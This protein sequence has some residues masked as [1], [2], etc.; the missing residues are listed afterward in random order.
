MPPDAGPNSGMVDRDQH[1]YVWPSITVHNLRGDRMHSPFHD[2]RM[3]F[4][5]FSRAPYD[6]TME[7]LS[8]RY[9]HMFD[10]PHN[11]VPYQPVHCE[12]HHYAPPTRLSPHRPLHGAEGPYAGATTNNPSMRRQSIDR[13][14]WAQMWRHP[15]L[16]IRRFED[17]LEHVADWYAAHTTSEVRQSIRD[18]VLVWFQHRSVCRYEDDAFL[19]SV[20][21]R[22]RSIM[23]HDLP[24]R[25]KARD[26]HTMSASRLVGPSM[27]DFRKVRSVRPSQLGM[28]KNHRDHMQ[29]ASGITGHQA[30]QI[31]ATIQTAS[32]MI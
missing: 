12:T 27:T 6:F 21:L 19:R 4:H 30:A 1:R 11:P 32:M 29:K 23:Y 10:S 22:I 7:G 28:Y 2:A 20:G 15:E 18:F 9:N 5:S 8:L 26:G 13:S 14:Y 31:L 16:P 24:M 25:L 3:L 17:E